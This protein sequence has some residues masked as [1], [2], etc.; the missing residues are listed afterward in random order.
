[1]RV[2]LATVPTAYSNL[3]D[4]KDIHSV[5]SYLFIYTVQ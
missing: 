3:A 1:M 2:A 4:A 5:H